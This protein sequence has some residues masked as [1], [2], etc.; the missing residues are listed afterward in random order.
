MGNSIRK[1]AP[2]PTVEFDPDAA[3]MHLNDLLG[4]GE[5]EA[6]TSFSFRVGA[7]DLVELLED[8]RPLVLRNAGAGVH[9]ADGEAPVDGIGLTRTPPGR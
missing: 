2:S 8:P 7:V 9:D 1:V 4:D 3:A 5:A 6:G